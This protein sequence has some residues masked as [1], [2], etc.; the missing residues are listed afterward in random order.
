[1][2]FVLTVLLSM[3]SPPL[4]AQAVD[5]RLVP[6]G[7]V[8]IS[9]WTAFE[10]WDER[11]GSG[12]ESGRVSLGQAISAGSAVSLFPGS[13][14]LVDGLRTLTGMGEYEPTMAAVDG[15]ISHDITR[16]DLGLHVGV[17]DWWT[18]G[19]IVPRIKNRSAVDMVFVP[20]TLGGDLGVSP[21]VT[22]PADVQAFLSALGA[23]STAAGTRADALCGSGDPQCASATSLAERAAMFDAGMTGVYGATP[24][25]PLDGSAIGASLGQAVADLDAEL[26]AAGLA[27]IEAPLV[28]S[29]ERASEADLATLPSRFDALGYATPLQT[30][31]GLWSWGDIEIATFARVLD[32]DDGSRWSLQVLAGGVA[33]LGTGSAPS[34]DVP[35]DLGAGDGQTD[36]EGRMSAY[37]TLGGRL[38]LR[39]GGL[40]GVQGSRDILRRE[41]APGDV[42]APVSTR[43]VFEWDPGAY[44]ILEAEPGIRMAAELT[45]SA[46][47]RYF[48]KAADTFRASDGATA[49][50][51]TASSY[52]HEVGG[53]LTYDTVDRSRDGDARPFRFRLRVLRAVWGGGM[54]TPASTRVDLGAE[55]FTTL[56][57]GR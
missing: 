9:A 1:M 25:F 19:V 29:A 6:S 7:S 43:A 30:R 45:L 28:L 39:M 27:G 33:R 10:A 16:I 22:A 31:T 48:G 42:L 2:S 20:D 55:L 17:T 3:A 11:F 38:S 54:S 44:H 12:G 13:S 37:A 18:V 21:Y 50:P 5:D 15:R 40:Y 57:G 4:A 36:I 52:R 8:R 46:T 26:T 56:W 35:L 53:S 47:Y 49:L 51:M 32:I 14:M 41:P 24:F 34:A 23:A